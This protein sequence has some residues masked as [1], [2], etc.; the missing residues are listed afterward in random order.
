MS[1]ATNASSSPGATMCTPSAVVPGFGFARSTASFA[2]SL[3]VP[4][5][6]DTDIPV[7]RLTASRIR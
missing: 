2:I 6:I 7:S 5:P 4:P 3:F 1:V